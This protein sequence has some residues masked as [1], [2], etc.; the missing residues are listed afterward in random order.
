MIVIDDTIKD[1]RIDN[2][3]KNIRRN[4]AKAGEKVT[5][6]FMENPWRTPDNHA[7]NGSPAVS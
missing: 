6:N 4:S 7:G 5:T 3:Y 1:E 2:F